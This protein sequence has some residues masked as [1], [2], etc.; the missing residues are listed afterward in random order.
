MRVA[1]HSIFVAV[2]GLIWLVTSVV[3]AAVLPVSGARLWLETENG[4][5]IAYSSSAGVVN[6]WLD[7]SGNGID[8]TDLD[9]DA[10]SRPTLTSSIAAIN[11]HLA[12]RFDG[13]DDY[14]RNGSSTRV[15]PAGTTSSTVF[16]VFAFDTT[17]TTKTIFDTESDSSTNRHLFGVVAGSTLLLVRDGGA[18]SITSTTLTAGSYYSSTG[19]IDGASSF[20][21]EAGVGQVNGTISNTAVTGGNDIAI[22]S[23]YS[24]DNSFF[25]GDLVEL[26]VYNS[27][28][29]SGNIA[30][31]EQYLTNKYFP[32]PEPHSL[33][34]M[35]IGAC[36]FLRRRKL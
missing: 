7:Q 9:P 28:L 29:S 33:L 26:I 27:A 1:I 21:R 18:G 24:L 20:L 34:L 23:R 25:K 2:L 16:A 12:V 11:N 3:Q 17:A 15:F 30:L 22:G 31:V 19:L 5:G 13:L 14:L 6:T 36:G 4:E 35:M 8:M 32:V 10:G